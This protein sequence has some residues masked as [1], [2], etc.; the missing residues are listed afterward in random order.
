M[1]FMVWCKATWRQRG[2]AGPIKTTKNRSTTGRFHFSIDAELSRMIF[3]Q[4]DGSIMQLIM[5]TW[6]RS[7]ICKSYFKAA[8][9][10]YKTIR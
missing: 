6:T 4:H 7:T 3:K 1:K 9:A 8:M 5:D 10:L 2:C